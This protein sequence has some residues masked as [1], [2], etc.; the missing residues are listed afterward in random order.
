MYPLPITTH[1]GSME[2]YLIPRMYS[3]SGYTDS[4]ALLW[5][6]SCS[7]PPCGKEREFLAN[8]LKRK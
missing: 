2:M 8:G 4:C 1:Y 3:V 5:M 6:A 7:K